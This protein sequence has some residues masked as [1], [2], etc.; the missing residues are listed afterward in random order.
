MSDK[1]YATLK[2]SSL[3]NSKSSGKNINRYSLNSDKKC[4]FKIKH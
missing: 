4:E 2:E 3:I 1:A